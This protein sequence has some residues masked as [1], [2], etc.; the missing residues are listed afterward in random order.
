MHGSIANKSEKRVARPVLNE[1]RE[2][3]EAGALRRH[4]F[5]SGS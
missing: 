2:I 1:Q 5:G 4:S 3:E